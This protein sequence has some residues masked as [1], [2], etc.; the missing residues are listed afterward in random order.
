MFC[1]K[2]K[3]KKVGETTEEVIKCHKTTTENLQITNHHKKF[4]FGAIIPGLK[5]FH[6]SKLCNSHGFWTFGQIF[7]RV[8]TV[9]NKQTFVRISFDMIASFRYIFNQM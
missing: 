1:T 4:N 8:N 3:M 5:N 9:L 6:R 2:L 7:F